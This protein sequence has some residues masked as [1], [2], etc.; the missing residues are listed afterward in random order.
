M[1]AAM[2]FGLAAA[3]VIYGLL[4]RKTFQ[5]IQKRYIL[6]YQVSDIPIHL[7]YLLEF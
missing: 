4:L 5:Q 6:C 1:S 3:Y 7:N 2:G